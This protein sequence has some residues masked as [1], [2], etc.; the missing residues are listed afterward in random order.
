M[1][2]HLEAL[3]TSFA[4][5]MHLGVFAFGVSFVEEIIAPIPSPFVMI[6]TGSLALVQGYSSLGLLVLLASGVIGK[7]LGA[8]VVYI[9]ADRV[10][11]LLMK[12]RLAR[13]FD[14]SHE[15][16]EAFGMHLKGGLR[17][18]FILTLLRALPLIP[19]VVVS[20]GSGVLKIPLRLYIVAT[21]C[22]TVIRDGIYLLFG[23]FGLSLLGVVISKSELLAS[24]IEVLTLIIVVSALLVLR[25]RRRM[26]ITTTT[27]TREQDL[28]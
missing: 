11:D 27:P 10:E 7:T 3:L 26:R 17:D 20:V 21:F 12:S 18:Y 13:F 24:H 2:G 19:S 23:Y 15:D 22:G 9:I 25:H 8:L 5:T 28:H 1:F 14:V 6:T 16:V 4:H